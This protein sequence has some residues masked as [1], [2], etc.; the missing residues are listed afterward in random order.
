MLQSASQSIDDAG[1]V[2]LIII[3]KSFLDNAYLTRTVRIMLKTTITNGYLKARCHRCLQ[4]RNWHG[5][6]LSI[7]VSVC[8]SRRKDAHASAI[9]PCL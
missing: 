4:S 1:T 7:R 3:S 6:K 2:R 9:L 5:S 8:E